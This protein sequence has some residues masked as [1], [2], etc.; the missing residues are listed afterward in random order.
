MRLADRRSLVI[1][2]SCLVLVGAAG[3]QEKRQAN[4]PARTQEKPKDQAAPPAFPAQVDL[5]TVDVVVTDKKGVPITGLTQGSFTVLEDGQPQG[6]ASFEAIQLPDKPAAS[7][8]P[9]PP[10]STNTATSTRA[11]RTFTVVFDD[12][13]LTPQ[14][15]YRA[16]GAVAD[17]LKNGVREGDIVTLVATSGAAWWSTR[18]EAGRDELLA[19]AKRL[20]GRNIPDMSPE[21]MSDYEAMRIHVYNDTQAEERVARRFE[22]YGVGTSRGGGN[23]SSSSQGA[24]I[25]GDPYVRGRATEVY[26]QAVSKNRITLDVI[27]R[28]LG[29]MT[30]TRGRKSLILVSEGFI[31]DPNL[32]EF[33]DVVQASRRAN[34]AM[35]FLDTRGL[36][37]MSV[38]ATAQFGPALPD[39]DVGYAF[40]EN[41]EA[42]E[43]AESLAADSGG[44]TVKNTNDLGRGIQRIADETRS[45]YLLG[46]NPTNTARDGRFRKIQVRVDRKNVE[47]RARKGYYAP[48][49]GVKV[50]ERKPGAPDPAFQTALDSPFDV[51]EIPL[52]MAS[53]VLDET[54]LGKASVVVA[55]EVDLRGFAFEEQE[56]RAV[57]SAEFLLVVAHRETGEFFR[58]DQKIDMKL[59]P[60]TRTR[61]ARTWLPIQRDFELAPGGYQAKIVVRDKNSGRVGTVVHRFDVPELGPFRLSTL[62]LTDTLRKPEGD[63][64]PTPTMLARRSFLAGAP[65]YCQF[66]VYG[67]AKDTKTG[68][69]KVSAG[70]KVLRADGSTVTEVAPSPIQPTSLGKLSRIVGSRLDDAAPGDYEVLLEVTDEISGKK[71]ELREP[72]V[73]EPAA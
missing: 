21:R 4:A 16:K 15:A 51:D 72:F 10:V 39:Q 11:G 14:G 58:Y 46:Y 61:M 42:S 23:S 45:Y 1:L 38:Y 18:M 47:V 63:N 5:V 43:G 49:D 22:T 62:V 9:P 20:D 30:G 25:D 2:A 48:L 34:V 69:P 40:T 73:I 33:R 68:M 53:Y 67:A 64:R 31:Y 57:D 66:E 3:A 17:F 35:Y 55:A 27:Q 28:V 19:L 50:A 70:Y 65:L 7:P 37:G 52:R 71:V 26:F 41:L 29:S 12:V 56:G 36:S 59:Q 54:L 6:I 8:P 60:E 13:H 24:T 44:F 32:G